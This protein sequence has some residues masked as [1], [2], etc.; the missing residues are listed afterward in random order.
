MGWLE[1]CGEIHMCLSLWDLCSF[2]PLEISGELA[3]SCVVTFVL[4]CTQ[5]LW[6]VRVEC[7]TALLK[8]RLDA[9]LFLK[10]ISATERSTNDDQ[11][12][13]TNLNF[14]PATFFL[15]YFD[16]GKLLS[17]HLNIKRQVTS[18]ENYSTCPQRELPHIY[19]L[20]PLRR[21][22]AE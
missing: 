19:S 2:S 8:H 17:S 21:N 10:E 14:T 18:N 12:A 16:I 13:E 11:C 22:T 20:H 15:V 9:F 7:K 5:V 6:V 1:R 4:D 3:S